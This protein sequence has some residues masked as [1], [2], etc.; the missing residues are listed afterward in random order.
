MRVEKFN[1]SSDLLHDFISLQDAYFTNEKYIK[2]FKESLYQTFNQDNP[3]FK[4]C[5]YSFFIVYSDNTPVA[6]ALATIDHRRRNEDGELVGNFGYLECPNDKDISQLLFQ[7]VLA[8]LKERNTTSVHGP[9]DLN[10]YENYRVMTTGFETSPFVGEPRNPRYYPLLLEELGFE[11]ESYWR[12]WEI[13]Q[14]ELSKFHSFLDKIITKRKNIHGIELIPIDIDK[15]ESSLEELYETALD[16]FSQNYGY[17]QIT[18]EEFISI[19]SKLKPFLLPGS[20]QIAK[21]HS[22]RI[23]G[24]MYGMLDMAQGLIKADGD[25]SALQ[26]CLNYQPDRYIYHTFGVIKDLRFSDMTARLTHSQTSLY[27]DLF[28]QS[29]AALTTSNKSIVDRIKKPNRIYKILK[30]NL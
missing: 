3:F 22:K 13:D 19:F 2:T 9:L 6:R 27:K 18:K 26:E 7:N 21:D 5:D 16:V 30:K 24:F 25:I 14:E 12:S 29:I 11:E 1:L 8:W 28:P 10:I 4:N 17:S 20:F 15:I 23:V